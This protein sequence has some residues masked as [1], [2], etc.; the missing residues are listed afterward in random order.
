MLNSDS[1]I[2]LLPNW[3]DP[4]VMTVGFRTDIFQSSDGCET[5]SSLREFPRISFSYESSSEKKGFDDKSS[6]AQNLSKY[7][8]F[9]DFSMEVSGEYVGDGTVEGAFD[10]FIWASGRGVFVKGKSKYQ[11]AKISANFPDRIELDRGSFFP[12]ERVFVY[13]EIVGKVIQGSSTANLSSRRK[14]TKVDLEAYAVQ[15]SVKAILDWSPVAWFRDRP[16]ALWKPNWAEVLDESWS[17]KEFDFDLGYSAPWFLRKSKSPVRT[18][19]HS[20]MLKTPDQIREFVS[21]FSYCRGR[22]ASF[23]APTWTDDFIFV[24]PVSAG[25][26]TLR[27]DGKSCLRLFEFYQSFKNISISK[28]NEVFLTGILFIEED[29]EG[30]TVFL[31]QPVPLSVHGAS[32]ASWLLRQ[33]FASDEVEVEYRTSS[34]ATTTVRTVSLPDDF[35][36]VTLAGEIISFGNSFLTIGMLRDFRS[37]VSTGVSGYN[38]TIGGEF[39]G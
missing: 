28:G 3:S 29:G 35:N 16:V 31:Q 20:V 7:V 2:F 32:S 36:E 5:R 21:F 6:I 13:P 12:G 14:T 10:Y 26:T 11:Y 17:F 15:D 27:V 22:Q 19:A 24:T 38:V 39:L 37:H 4:V 23:Y 30:C 9:P 34:V 25:D 33:R 1:Q 18:G 8:G